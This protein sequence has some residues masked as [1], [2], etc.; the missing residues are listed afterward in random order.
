MEPGR[1][2][3]LLV[4]DEEII[5]DVTGLMLKQIG[6][7]VVIAHNGTEAID[8]Y[9]THQTHIDLVILDMV[10]PDMGG[11][12]T[13]ER[14]KAMNPEVRVILSSGYSLDAEASAIL[15]RG[16]SDFIQKPFDLQSLAQKIQD[17]LV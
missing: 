2:T 3:I 12:D 15:E 7:E 17:V 1:Q 16:C 13:Y 6:F 11:G 4:D 8:L 9:Q 5:V 10:M 14:L